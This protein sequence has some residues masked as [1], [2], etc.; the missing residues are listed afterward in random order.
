MSRPICAIVGADEGLDRA[1]AAPDAVA[2]T[3]WWAHRQP[4]AA[5]SNEI[6]VRPHTESWTW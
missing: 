4:K 5:W 2:Q 6:E 1:L 3:C